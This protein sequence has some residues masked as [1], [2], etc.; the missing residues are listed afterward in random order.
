MTYTLDPGKTEMIL[1]QCVSDVFAETAFIDVQ[2]DAA[3][4]GAESTANRFAAIDVLSPLS[5]RI[6]IG[7]NQNILKRIADILFGSSGESP[8]NIK[9][10]ADD[11]ILEILNIITGSF[12]TRYFGAGTE[13]Q[14][15]LP[16]YLYAVSDTTGDLVTR[17]RMDAEGD[18]IEILLVSVRY[19]Y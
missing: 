13:F 7:I 19:R 9:K 17:F 4:A 16:Q 1:A 10:Y 15:E 6:Q 18:A 2:E 11:S 14:L 8:A 5:C 12:L 3:Q